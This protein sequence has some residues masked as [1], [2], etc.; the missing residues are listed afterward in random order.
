M[1]D[2]TTLAV[3][4]TQHGIDSSSFDDTISTVIA[5]VSLTIERYIGRTITEG[6]Y[7]DEYL[8]GD[9]MSDQ[10][11]LKNWPVTSAV[12]FVLKEDGSTVASTNYT[13][14]DSSGIIYT[15]PDYYGSSAWTRG[16]RNFTVTYSA[17]YA[18][19]PADIKQAA[20][21]QVRRQLYQVQPLGSNWLG[22]KSI[23]EAPGFVTVYETAEL[24]PGVRQIL[25]QYRRRF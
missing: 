9:G 18:T 11:V 15:L 22:K 10:L 8:N 3:V 16:R 12:T 23:S 25:N 5:A 7:S 4:K 14:D 2:L 24:L 6:T 21:D 17:G 19:V 1:G 20:T 13:V